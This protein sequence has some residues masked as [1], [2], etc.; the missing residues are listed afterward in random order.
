M[1]NPSSSQQLN[2]ASKWT[3][4]TKNVLKEGVFQLVGSGVLLFAFSS[5]LL[6]DFP[7]TLSIKKPIT[8]V[9]LLIGALA[10]GTLYWVIW[11]LRNLLVVIWSKN[12]SKKQVTITNKRVFAYRSKYRLHYDFYISVDQSKMEYNIE[13]EMYSYLDIGDMI[14]LEMNDDSH[15]VLSIQVVSSQQT[16]DQKLQNNER[17]LE[18]EL[19]VAKKS[20]G[21]SIKTVLMAI[22]FFAVFMAVVLI[23]APVVEGL[24][25]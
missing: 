10:V 1:E 12:I 4:I 6:E 18:E 9:T 20:A 25:G 24:F 22:V 5:I 21:L 13:R 8:I 16:H 3:L 23:L 11:S 17:R 2:P 7:H 14:E 19:A 15:D